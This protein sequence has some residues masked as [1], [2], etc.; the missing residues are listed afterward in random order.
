MNDLERNYAPFGTSTSNISN[1][2]IKSNTANAT[3]PTT[4]D[5]TSLQKKV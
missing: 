3:V 4:T 1:N 2:Y 5:I